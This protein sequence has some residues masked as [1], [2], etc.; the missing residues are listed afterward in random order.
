MSENNQIQTPT[1]PEPSKDMWKNRRR[2]AY[3]SMYS[4]IIFVSFVGAILTFTLVP[5]TRIKLFI[6][7]LEVYLVVASSVVAA[8]IGF[9][10]WSLKGIR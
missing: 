6:D 4:M 7:L 9:A 3:I 8:Y 1:T 5:E 2:M 10:T